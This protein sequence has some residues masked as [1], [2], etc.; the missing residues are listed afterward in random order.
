MKLGSIIFCFLA[1]AENAVASVLL[2]VPYAT[3]GPVGTLFVGTAPNATATAYH[4]DFPSNTAS[5]IY[6]FGTT[7][8]SAGKDIAFTS[9]VVAQQ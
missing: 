2:T 4:F 6:S 5:V 3:S 9:L 8:V 7:T 1:L